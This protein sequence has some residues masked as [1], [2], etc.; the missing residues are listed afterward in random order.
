MY[1]CQLCL[2]PY[3]HNSTLKEHL[4][5]SH[6]IGQPFKC[7]CGQV[8]AHRRLVTLHRTKC[9]ISKQVLV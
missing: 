9:D 5:G 1:V 6:G 7:E 3:K 2:K 8:F 4:R